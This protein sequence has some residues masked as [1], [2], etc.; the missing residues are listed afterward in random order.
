MTEPKDGTRTCANCA[1]FAHMKP[2]GTIVA[3]GAAGYQTVCRRNVPGARAVRVEVPRILDGKPVL[4]RI[5]RP[6]M[7]PASAFQYGYQP[8]P[9][10]AVCFDGW[11]P[12]GTLP[13]D[14]WRGQSPAT[15]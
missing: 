5:G 12:A 14:D 10:D 6:V 4:D 1:C 11:R 9:A 2:D 3:D 7:E 13:G 8:T 15:L